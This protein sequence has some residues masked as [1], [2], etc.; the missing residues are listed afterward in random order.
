M[1]LENNLQNF[2]LSGT[3]ANNASIGSV[4]DGEIVV[5]EMA[6]EFGKFTPFMKKQPQ[7]TPEEREWYYFTFFSIN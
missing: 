7:N 1:N 6:L 5:E 2:D 4:L 3:G